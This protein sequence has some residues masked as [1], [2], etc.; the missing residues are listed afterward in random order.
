MI[1]NGNN[2]IP[3]F[4]ARKRCEVN[5]ITFLRLYGTSVK[6]LISLKVFRTIII[7]NVNGSNIEFL[8]LTLNFQSFNF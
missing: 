1:L 8:I 7:L 4:I 6:M 2:L 5:L 3:N